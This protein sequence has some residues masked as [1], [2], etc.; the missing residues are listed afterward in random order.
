LIEDLKSIPTATIPVIKAIIDLNK[1]KIEMGLVKPDSPD[2]ISKL[3]IDITFDGS[4]NN[5]DEIDQLLTETGAI[6]YDYN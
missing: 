1:L 6:P 4:N 3:K 5:D 2:T